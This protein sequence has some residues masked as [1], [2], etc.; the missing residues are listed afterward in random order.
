MEDE[1]DQAIE[2][3]KLLH[4]LNSQGHYG[5]YQSLQ[6]LFMFKPTEPF[7]RYLLIEMLRLA[8]VALMVLNFAILAAWTHYEQPS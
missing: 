8:A 7:T 2:S 4:V 3:D 1:S 5:V 6:T